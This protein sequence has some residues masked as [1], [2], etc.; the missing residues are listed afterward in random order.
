MPE[1][2]EGASGVNACQRAAP[3]AQ[4]RKAA[5]AVDSADASAGSCNFAIFEEAKSFLNVS[6]SPQSDG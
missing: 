6:R 2:R 5:S 3:A 4:N 1:Q